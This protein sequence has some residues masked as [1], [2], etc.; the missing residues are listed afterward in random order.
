MTRLWEED[1]E[2]CRSNVLRLDTFKR[3][4]GPQ[5][6]VSTHFSST[7]QKLSAEDQKTAAGIFRYLVTPSG[8]K[9]AQTAADLADYSELPNVSV[10]SV[11]EKLSGRDIRILRAISPPP[12][13]QG[14]V[15]YEIFHDVLSGPI[16]E[17][18]RAY[19]AEA[20]VERA[21]LEAVRDR[22]VVRARYLRRVAF[23]LSVM[24]V[25]V[26]GVMLYAFQQQ[27]LAAESAANERKAR[28]GE[29]A[30]KKMALE[31]AQREEDAKND[32]EIQKEKALRNAYIAKQAEEAAIIA[33][34]QALAARD[35]ADKRTR[36]LRAARLT[37]SLYR[38]AFRQSRR[39]D[40]K[41]DAIE[42][43]KKALK[44][45][46]ESKEPLDHQAATDTYIN[47]G[48][49]H[50]D[51]GNEAAASKSFQD[52]LA[53]CSTKT[54][55]ASA[56]RN[57]GD[58]YKEVDA[59]SLGFDVDPRRVATE[60][61]NEAL[62]IYQTL[63][64]EINQAAVL[65]SLALVKHQ[66]APTGEVVP[67]REEPFRLIEQAIELYK[68]KNDHKGQGFAL[69]TLADTKARGQYYM[70]PALREPVI[71]KMEQS[72]KEYELAQDVQGQIMVR[73]R[74]VLL[75]DPLTQTPKALE[76]L[77][78]IARLYTQLNDRTGLAAALVDTAVFK[79]RRTKP[80]SDEYPKFILDY[81]KAAELY[82]QAERPDKAALTWAGVGYHYRNAKRTA[83]AA[84][85]YEKAAKLFHQ[86][87]NRQREVLALYELSILFSETNNEKAL[88]Y[89][90]QL[91]SIVDQLDKREKAPALFYLGN[92]FLALKDFVK[93][94]SYFE[95]G[96]AIYHDSRE[97][98]NQITTLQRISNA[99]L[100][101]SMFDDSIKYLKRLLVLYQGNP[102]GEARTFMSLGSAYL[103]NGK[104]QDAIQNYQ[105][106]A[107]RYEAQ[108][109]FSEQVEALQEIGKIYHS[110]SLF[111]SAITTF[112]TVRQLFKLRL[113][114]QPN[115]EGIVV[116]K[117]AQSY[118]AKKEIPKAIELYEEAAKFYNERE[119]GSEESKALTAISAIYEST[120][121]TK[122]AALYK[123]RAEKALQSVKAF[124]P[125]PGP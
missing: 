55:R 1:V 6:I 99:Y 108:K 124:G 96:L 71:D 35:I 34:D 38:D 3:L 92:G 22:E 8:T 56:L 66:T 95:E 18:W 17:W 49:V 116:M 40:Q 43:F 39:K 93:A 48:E 72:L 20:R 42:N 25:I 69:Y 33:K 37:D 97:V 21:R 88:F 83:D 57:I 14:D 9:I 74:L 119:L 41:V 60:R 84:E 29:E 52:A 59:W 94:S 125:P 103:R 86:V 19:E 107:A 106:A 77:S 82:E 76:N 118:E 123:Q 64:D 2:R 67:D 28:L 54:E 16:N 101:P 100:T 105:S 15:R 78:A 110:E 23:G 47:I 81:R 98:S 7:M 70:T 109:Y 75:F 24:L 102:L 58:A 45:Y 13:Q 120:N 115:A 90:T 30:A 112:N 11:L 31:R 12:N 117:L 89:L 122:N 50:V 44:V 85:S 80:E 32:A 26:F 91:R 111:D 5:K 61:Y 79:L 36:E 114:D 73:K 113:I 104:P 87:G 27:A 10:S 62:S 68:R 51:V 121:D 65:I 4:A 53:R 46:L 63:G